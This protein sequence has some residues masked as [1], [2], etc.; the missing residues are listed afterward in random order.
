[1]LG[2]QDPR[3]Q[4]LQA[5]V[6]ELDLGAALTRIL[7][8]CG[9]QATLTVILGLKEDTEK[10]KRTYLRNFNIMLGLYAVT[11]PTTIAVGV[12]EAINYQSQFKTLDLVLGAIY[13]SVAATQAI[14][15]IL[16]RH[17]KGKVVQTYDSNIATCNKLEQ[18]AQQSAPA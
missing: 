16:T 8:T 12:V 3:R 5:E 14:T 10:A 4:A 9:R 2:T 7:N 13:F 15:A 18:M 11:I 1:M 6:E 17:Q